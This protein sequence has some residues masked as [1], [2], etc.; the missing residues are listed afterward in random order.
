MAASSALNNDF[1]IQ[2]SFM[3][4]LSAM[5]HLITF[6]VPQPEA[7]PC[8]P[9]WRH[10]SSALA[11]E[12]PFLISLKVP[13]SIRRGPTS[14]RQLWR[15]RG[16]EIKI[17]ITCSALA[18]HLNMSGYLSPSPWISGWHSVISPCQSCRG[19][20]DICFRQSLHWRHGQCRVSEEM[21]SISALKRRIKKPD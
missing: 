14:W 5:K 16:A 13:A 15:G 2:H 19:P 10:L 21:C 17:P 4:Y 12:S 7:A 8:P 18:C 9:G 1:N 11:S 6:C 3:S 20:E